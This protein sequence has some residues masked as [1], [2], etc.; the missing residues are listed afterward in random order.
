MYET[1]SNALA[2][3]QDRYTAITV[4]EYQDVNLLQQTCQSTGYAIAM[5]CAWSETTTRQSS[6]S[7]ALAPSTFL[8]MTR[9][10]ERATVIR[11]ETNYRSTPQILEWANRQPSK[12][13]AFRRSSSPRMAKGPSLGLSQYSN[14]EA[15]LNGV[16]I[17]IK[18]LIR[19][20][21]LPKEIAVL[22]RVNARSAAFEHAFHREQIPFQVAGGG[23]AERPLEGV[24]KRLARS[25]ESTE[26]KAHVEDDSTTRDSL[27]TSLRQKSLPK[28]SLDN[29]TWP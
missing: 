3:F 16:L 7:L 6:G 8:E 27:E 23:F 10:Y 9:R 11:L 1:D 19:K 17:K 29:K 24:R 14:E 15:E 25:P 26:L 28:S 22:Y 2:R 20:G 13:A 4:D 12:S 18:E 5:T 21:V